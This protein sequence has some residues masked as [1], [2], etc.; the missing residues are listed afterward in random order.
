LVSQNPKDRTRIKNLFSGSGSFYNDP[1]DLFD[2]LIVD[3]AH[4]LKQK[5]AFQYWGENQVKDIVKS[6][7]VSVFFIDDSQRIRPEDVGSVEEIKKFAMENGAEIHEIELNA[8]F[9]CSGAT[10]FIQWVDNVLQLRETGN[11]DGWD[12]E[13]FDFKVCDTPQEV[14]ELIKG[15]VSEGLT[16]GCSPVMRGSGQLRIRAT[17]TAK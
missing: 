8:Q 14:H 12:K 7:K 10:G 6:A 15:K 4:R 16:L 2:V 17:E 13:S 11:F 5:G 9:R 3:E 1:L